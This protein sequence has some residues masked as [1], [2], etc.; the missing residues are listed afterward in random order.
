MI[1]IQLR[2]LDHDNNKKKVINNLTNKDIINNQETIRNLSMK[3][4]LIQDL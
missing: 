2:N 4:P 3:L 1:L